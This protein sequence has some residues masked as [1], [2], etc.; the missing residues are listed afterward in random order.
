M[1]KEVHGPNAIFVEFDTKEYITRCF[2]SENLLKCVSPIIP[3]DGGDRGDTP[4]VKCSYRKNK[5][6]ER[7]SERNVNSPK[8]KSESVRNL[9]RIDEIG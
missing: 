7:F 6:S 5:I 4:A 8:Q 3:L 2:E 9:F 1:Q